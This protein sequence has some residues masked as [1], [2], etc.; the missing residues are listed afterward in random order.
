GAAIMGQRRE[1]FRADFL[2]QKLQGPNK[3]SLGI[4]K[5]AI[6]IASTTFMFLLRVQVVKELWNSTCAT[7]PEMKMGYVWIA[8]PIMA[9]TM[10]IYTIS[11]FVNH[12]RVLRA[13]EVSE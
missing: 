4:L 9:A 3:V 1:H 2:I 13:K 11:H 7:I 8:I 10:I 12:I 5:V 6:L